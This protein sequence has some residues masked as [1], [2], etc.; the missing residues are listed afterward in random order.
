ML[1]FKAIP[2]LILCNSVLKIRITFRYVEKKKCFACFF[3]R[4]PEE[5]QTTPGL[6][7]HRRLTA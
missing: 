1:L 3:Q 2:P 5:L 7:T 4:T 6:G